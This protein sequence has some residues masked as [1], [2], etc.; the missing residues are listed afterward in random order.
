MAEATWWQRGVIYQIYPRSFMDGDGDGVGDLPGILR[1]LDHL[2]WLGVDA[3]WLSP[4]HPS[5]MDDFGYDVSDYTDV[6]PVFGTL[7]DLDELVAAAHRRGLRVLL[8]WVPNHTSDRHPWF[9]A[10]RASRDGAR[11]D[12]YVWRDPR[13]DGGPPTNWL[14]YIGDSAW[15]WDEPTGQFYYRVFLD[16]Q[17]DLNWRNPQVQEAMFDTLRFWLARGIDGFRIDALIVLVEDDR[18]RDNPPNPGYRPGQDMP[19]LRE[20][21]VWN[22]DRPETRELAARMR[23]VVDEFGD[24]RVLLAELGLPLEQA[25]AYYGPD[26]SGI[27]VPFNFGLLTAAWDARGIAAYVD[28][29]LAALPAGAWPNWVLGN[30]DS[31]RVASRLGPAQ[32]RVAAMLLLTLPGTPILYQGEELGLEDV[33]IPDE[34]ALDPIARLVPGHGRDPERTRCPGTP[35]PAPASRVAAPGCPSASGTGPGAWPPS[36]TTP[37]PCSPCTAACCGSAA[38]PRPWSPAPTSR[39]RP[40]ATSSPTCAPA[41]ATAT[42]SPSTS[43]PTR[44][45]WPSPG[46]RPVA[47]RW[48]RPTPAA[49]ARR[50]A[51]RWSCAATRAWSSGP[52][53]RSRGGLDVTLRA[54]LALAQGRRLHATP[55]TM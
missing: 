25:V 26:G 8:D 51:G 40:T 14:R 29:Y 32:A 52:D 6:D 50:S 13:P 2:T 53:P 47:G 24:D 39:S 16:S 45:A 31:P 7:A 37:P 35:A 49:T 44:P 33:P 54:G 48:S 12:W 36:A 30:H 55:P 9:Q 41:T 34:E 11:R 22:V 46:P 1:R 5:P 43:A 28:R 3:V 21:S 19:Y 10:S 15:C 38:P 42:W 23:K 27:Q 4:V 20:L 17:P 18:L